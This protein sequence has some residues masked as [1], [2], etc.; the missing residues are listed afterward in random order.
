LKVLI[1]IFLLLSGCCF[2][3]E[4]NEITRMQQKLD[5]LQTINDNQ[6]E[7][8]LK[9]SIEDLK[10]ENDSLRMVIKMR[11]TE[12]MLNQGKHKSLE[13]KVENEQKLNSYYVVISSNRSSDKIQQQKSELEQKFP[14]NTLAIVQNDIKTWYHLIIGKGYDATTIG[15]AVQSFKNKGI[16]DAWWIYSLPDKSTSEK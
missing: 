10:T 9:A 4:Q 2:A 11:D 1:S 12:L 5:S 7:M 16:H 8:R 14:S 3:Q 13:A 6:L 15:L